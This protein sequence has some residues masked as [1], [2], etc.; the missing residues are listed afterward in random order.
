MEKQINVLSIMA[1]LY[2]W[3]DIISQVNLSSF[4]NEEVLNNHLLKR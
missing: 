1:G 4:L 2:A 3:S